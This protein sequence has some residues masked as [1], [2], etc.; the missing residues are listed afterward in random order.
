[1]N[2]SGRPLICTDSD[3]AGFGL[4]LLGGK[5]ATLVKLKSLGFA[6]PPFYVVSTAAWQAAAMPHGLTDRIANR[7][8]EISGEQSNELTNAASEIRGWIETMPLPDDLAAALRSHP[9]TE[10]GEP[11]AVRSSA[12]D[13]D[14]G[15][16]SFAGLHDSFLG[17]RGFELL[18]EAIKKVWASA[19]SQ[20]AIEY[21]RHRGC[22][23]AEIAVAVVVQPLLAVRSSGV[24]FTAHPVSGNVHELVVNSL[25]GFGEGLVSA[26][27]EADAYIVDKE[28]LAVTSELARKMTQY[29]Y[30]P[31]EY[32]RPQP[33]P[34]PE[35]LVEASSLT[36]HEITELAEIG[37]RIE[38]A[39]GRP[40]DIE[41][42]VDKSGQVH[43]LQARPITV[44]M[45]QYGPAAGNRLIWDNSNIIESYYGVTTPMTFSF[46]RRAYTIVYHCFAEVMGIS[47]RKVRA[48][49][50]TF[51]NMLGLFQ[52][53]V[54]YNLFS[55]YRLLRLFP[56]FNF[57]QQFLESMMGLKEPVE[58][59]EE[60]APPGW[61]QRYFVELPALL[62][63]L[64]RSIWNFL[65]IR[66][67]A[68]RFNEKVDR[69]LKEWRAIDFA[70][71]KPHEIMQ[72][73]RKMED[74]LLWD[75]KAPIIN[76]FYVMIYCGLL[77][78]LCSS[79]GG[80]SSGALANDLLCGESSIASAE[81]VR[82]LL[83][84]ARI[85]NA[86]PDLRQLLL[87]APLQS[88]TEILFSR[89]QFS[90]FATALQSYLDLY[91]ARRMNELKLEARSFRDQPEKLLELLRH[92]LQGETLERSESILQGQ[93]RVRDDAETRA[94][95]TIKQQRLPHFKSLLF[96]R[97]LQNCRIGVSNREEMRFA[98]TR[99]YDLLRDMLRALGKQFASEAVI[100]APEDIFY[101][102]LDEVWD[103]IKGTAVTT[104]L[105]GLVALRRGE[106]ARYAEDVESTPSRRF[107]T[108]G[109]AYHRNHVNGRSATVEVAGDEGVLQGAPCSSG[110]ATGSVRVL[111]EPDPQALQDGE[112]LVAERTDPGWALIYPTVSGILIERGSILSHS[113]I[114]ARELGVPAIVAIPDL[115]QRLQ[116]GDQVAMDGST[117]KVVIVK[118][119]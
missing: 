88:Q 104:D 70:A 99:V 31:H 7:L 55:W 54:Y 92:Y 39:L 18:Q 96:R 20:R 24:L 108:Y 63:L 101:L 60:N 52:G 69:K 33:S 106:Y 13:E 51:E 84:L 76:D 58:L 62:R 107:E 74:T 41:F 15:D 48:N 2:R 97:V 5:A 65:R 53:R 30:V 95:A 87:E 117:G 42:A 4:T 21:R 83:Q 56:G 3:A 16:C 86:S 66:L 114:V 79:W 9:W 49:R 27:L 44:E 36:P 94:F 50:H 113:A 103:Y 91:G 1:M 57:N 102:T 82:R 61:L 75:W 59:R 77:R 37:L 43:V 35:E 46:I 105:K 14:G 115:I 80:D 40:Q 67:I 19:F 68:R 64:M 90:D 17:I 109:M 28:T 25:Y 72:L 45:D 89:P 11:L 32:K 118:K 85:A 110:E 71:K 116:T 12:A 98:R 10:S 29:T 112:I 119:G 81:P 26:G 78:K 23:I 22:E 34:V 93:T 6:V 8:L 111:T 38:R 47:P 73:Y 100:N